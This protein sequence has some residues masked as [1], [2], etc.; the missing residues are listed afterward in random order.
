MTADKEKL[1][2]AIIEIIRLV[3]LVAV[4]EYIDEEVVD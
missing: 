3:A 2:P 4:E 1:S